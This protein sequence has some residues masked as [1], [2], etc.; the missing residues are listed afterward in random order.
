M[1]ENDP[2][3]LASKARKIDHEQLKQALEASSRGKF[4]AIEANSGD[5]F[6]R[7]EGDNENTKL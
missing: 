2:R 3:A 6:Y 4:V 5:Y 7:K 1:R